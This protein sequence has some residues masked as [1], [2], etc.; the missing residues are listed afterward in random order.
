MRS[1][2]HGS[3]P[4]S[5]LLATPGETAARRAG[6][7][8]HRTLAIGSPQVC[9]LSAT[10]LEGNHDNVGGHELH[11]E[12]HCPAPIRVHGRAMRGGE[13]V[14]SN[15]ADCHSAR[16]DHVR[17]PHNMGGRQVLHPQPPLGILLPRL[18][19]CGLC[20]CSAAQMCCKDTDMT[21]DSPPGATTRHSKACCSRASGIPVWCLRSA[22]TIGAPGAG[23]G[24]SAAA[25]NSPVRGGA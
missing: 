18:G 11:S 4:G 16:Q 15:S 21:S 14:S 22:A 23:G 12:L 2:S 20:L 3:A 25:G 10:P 17:V 1:R 7:S 19:L 9:G 8:L 6:R 5:C 24:P 13:G